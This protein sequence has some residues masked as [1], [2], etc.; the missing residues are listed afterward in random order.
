[1]AFVFWDAAPVSASIK[2]P[3]MAFDQNHPAILPELLCTVGIVPDGD[4]VIVSLF[5]ADI[6][7]NLLDAYP[8]A[9]S[10]PRAFR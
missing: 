10:P 3:D 2:E 8:R 9:P 1:L 5:H 7:V 4:T 6:R